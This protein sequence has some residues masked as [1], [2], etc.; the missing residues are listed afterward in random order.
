[1]FLQLL[2]ILLRCALD[3]FHGSF[4]ALKSLG[5]VA[6][7]E[8]GPGQRIRDVG[9]FALAQVVRP[10]RGGKGEFD[11]LGIRL[12]IVIGADGYFRRR[13]ARWARRVPLSLV[14]VVTAGYQGRGGS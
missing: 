8:V 7:D 2:V 3:E 13:D 11:E 4:L 9:V 10:E 12:A 14:R 5:G 1:M 6:T